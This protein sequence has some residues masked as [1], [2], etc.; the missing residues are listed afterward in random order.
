MLHVCGAHLGRRTTL[1]TVPPTRQKPIKSRI[2]TALDHGSGV[3][4]IIGHRNAA[5]I[6]TPEKGKDFFYNVEAHESTCDS[7]PSG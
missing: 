2:S 1:R 6:T 3:Q 5:M 7:W 4:F